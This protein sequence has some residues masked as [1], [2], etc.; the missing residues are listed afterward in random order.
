MLLNKLHV[1]VAPHRSLKEKQTKKNS[2]MQDCKEGWKEGFGIQHGCYVHRFW[3]R[4]KRTA[5]QFIFD[6]S[7]KIRKSIAR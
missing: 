7:P 2:K 1:F 3:V 4:D 5:A 6:L